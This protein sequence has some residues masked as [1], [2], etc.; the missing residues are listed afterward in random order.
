M[1]E[2]K[3]GQHFVLPSERRKQARR[4]GLPLTLAQGVTQVLHLFVTAS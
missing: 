3:N 4:T 1:L 2:R